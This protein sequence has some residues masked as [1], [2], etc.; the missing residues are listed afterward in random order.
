MTRL[1][2]LSIALISGTALLTAC[3]SDDVGSETSFSFEEDDTDDD[4]GE[5]TTTEAGEESTSEDGTTEEGTTEEGTTEEGTTEEETTEGETTEEGTTEEE[6]TE[7]EETGCTLGT[8]DCECE[9][10]LEGVCEE[11]LVCLEGYCAEASCGDGIVSGDE[12]CDDGNDVDD[13]GCSNMCTLPECGDGVLAGD[14]QC[15][16]GNDVNEDECTN[17]CMLAVCGDGYLQ[18]DEECDD[19]NDVDD[20]ECS[21]DCTVNS[22]CGGEL[23][24]PG[25]GIE[26]CWYTAPTVGMT[27]N[28]LCSTH[29]GFNSAATQH[30]G[31]AIGMFFWPGKTNGSNWETIECSST[32]N[33][34]NWGANNSVPQ[35][36]WSHPAC[37]VNCACNQ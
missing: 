24:D 37:H 26:G 7:G 8:L 12:Q 22:D 25:N 10:G 14:E 23:I 35:A 28:E 13:D 16:D 4:V 34:T 20:D 11:G 31:N 6:T 29:G 2:V 5:D 30:A 27:C 15:D 32:D 3:P 18:G 17:E 21:N 36:D 9:G 33:N 1:S 19:G